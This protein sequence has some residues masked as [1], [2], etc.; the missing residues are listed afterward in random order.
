M[1][2]LFK[3]DCPIFCKH[4]EPLGCTASPEYKAQCPKTQRKTREKWESRIQSDRTSHT[5]K[6]QQVGE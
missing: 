3:V 1:F 4:R 6:T 5:K 2:R